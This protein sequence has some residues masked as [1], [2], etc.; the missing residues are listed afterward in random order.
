MIH[1]H[2][3]HWCPIMSVGGHVI[4]DIYE[5]GGIRAVVVG[6]HVEMRVVI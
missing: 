3:F 2:G 4:V 5:F 1:E 6:D